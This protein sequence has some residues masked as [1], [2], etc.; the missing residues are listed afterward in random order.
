MKETAKRTEETKCRR[1]KPG[2]DN[3]EPGVDNGEPGVES[4]EPGVDIVKKGEQKRRLDEPTIIAKRRLQE[5]R[6]ELFQRF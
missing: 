1:V 5:P 2:V 4:G 6:I 3:G